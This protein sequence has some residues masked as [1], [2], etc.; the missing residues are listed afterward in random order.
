MSAW[1]ALKIRIDSLEDFE[2]YIDAIKFNKGFIPQLITLHNTALPTDKQWEDTYNRDIE[3]GLIGGITRIN[4]L[5]HYF[6][7]DQGWP[8]GPHL[9]IW[10]KQIWLFTPLNEK[11]THSPSW[12]GI[13]IGIE[14]VA[15]FSKE[16]DDSGYGLMTRKTTIAVTA[17]LCQKLKINPLVGIKLH[18]EDKRTNH[19]CPGKDFA[20][21]KEE[22]IEEVLEYMGHAG[23]YKGE[24]PVA[25]IK[26]GIV[27]VP[28]NDVL[29]MRELSSASSKIL[30]K[31]KPNTEIKI[32]NED[33]NG[34]T[35]WLYVDFKNTKGWVAARYIKEI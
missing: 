10:R 24:V 33:M 16:D 9:F 28:L 25:K 30:L 12:N 11:G 22:V 35:K 4:S 5:E 2:K 1:P 3:K 34:K 13:G 20:E 23:D 17:L 7:V 6:K 26:Y 8:S 15:D 27:N 31:L 32:L 18:K 29:N 14:M 19:D 21:D